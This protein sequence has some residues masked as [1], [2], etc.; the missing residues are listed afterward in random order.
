MPTTDKAAPK[1]EKAHLE[2]CAC[3]VCNQGVEDY[4]ANEGGS[5]AIL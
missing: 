1:K 2:D 5:G 3:D 4:P